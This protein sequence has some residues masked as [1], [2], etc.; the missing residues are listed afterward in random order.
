METDTTNLVGGDDT[1]AVDTDAIAAA[2]AGV[3]ADDS[4]VAT[5]FD[6]AGNPIAGP[7]EDEEVDLDD[8]KLTVPKSAAQKLKELKEG[9]LR[10]A[11][12]TRKTQSLAEERKAFEAKVQQYEQVS[13][14]EALTRAQIAQAR[15]QIAN[16]QQAD[17]QGLMAA[18]AA[19]KQQAAYNFDEAAMQAADAE[20]ANINAH[21]MRY[22][23]LKDLESNAQNY[24][25]GIEQ[26]RLSEAQRIHAERVEQGRAALTKEIPGWNDEHKAKLT[27]FAAEFGFSRE[28]I[29]D[30]EADPRVARVLQAAFEG[31]TAKRAAT[32]LANLANTKQPQPAKVLRGTTAASPIKPDTNDFRAFEKLAQQKLSS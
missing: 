2:D 5:Q 29:D 19:R 11:D 20:I 9:A 7:E 17:W 28:E 27:G 10:Q 14:A 16:Y 18:A 21:H 15:T 12:Y 22:T 3:A 31:S 13:E 8:L 26:Q 30:L 32:K 4:Q 24:L 25:R 23:Q 1:A 6:E